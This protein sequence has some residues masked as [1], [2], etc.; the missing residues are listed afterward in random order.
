MG[1][2]QEKKMPVQVKRLRGKF[3]IVEEGTNRLAR[4]KNDKP[5]DGGGHKSRV[6]A[7]RQAAHINDSKERDDG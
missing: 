4:S 6:K 1:Y 2:A 3:R 5:M 7:H